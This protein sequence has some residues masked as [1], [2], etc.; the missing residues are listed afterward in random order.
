MSN[1]ELFNESDGFGEKAARDQLLVMDNVSR[2]AD[3]SK[4]FA[5]FLTIACKFN[6]TCVY[7]SHNI[8]PKKSIWRTI[9]SQTNI[10]TIFPASVSI[11]HVRKILESIC[12]TKTRTYIPQKTL[13]ISSSM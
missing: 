13:S 4:K 5:S 6:Y 8:Y 10:F 11:A 9:L 1:D 2:L 7:I 12:I 3:K